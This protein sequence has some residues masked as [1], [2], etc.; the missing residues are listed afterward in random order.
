MKVSVVWEGN[1]GTSAE[2]LRT[3]MRMSGLRNNDEN[4]GQ[5]RR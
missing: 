1:S 3:K 5:D 4:M 2:Q